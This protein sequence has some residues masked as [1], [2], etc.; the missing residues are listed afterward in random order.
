[1]IKLPLVSSVSSGALECQMWVRALKSSRMSE[2]L[3]RLLDVD[4]HLHHVDADPDPRIS[5]GKNGSGSG[6]RFS[7]W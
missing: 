1:M 7:T 4:R 3:L 2:V 6:S 5:I